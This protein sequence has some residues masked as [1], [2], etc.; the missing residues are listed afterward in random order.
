MLVQRPSYP[1][2]PRICVI[3]TLRMHLACTR[4]K[5]GDNEALFISSLGQFLKEQLAKALCLLC[6]GLG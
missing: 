3:I 6:A 2:D 1:S 4:F 5:R